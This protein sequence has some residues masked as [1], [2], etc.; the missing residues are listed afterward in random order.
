[1]AREC[2]V[3]GQRINSSVYVR[4][5]MSIS[6]QWNVRSR[7]QRRTEDVARAPGHSDVI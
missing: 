3:S 2:L 4:F 5:G 7:L 6:G 1:M